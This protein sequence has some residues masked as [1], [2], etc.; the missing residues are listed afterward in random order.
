MA[1]LNREGWNGHVP[2]VGILS[3]IAVLTAAIYGHRWIVLSNESS[4]SEGNLDYL[5]MTVNHQYSKSFEF[6]QN[7]Q[8][9]LNQ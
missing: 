7:F 6:E 2:L 5:G 1:E 3:W 4:A 9:Y 8:N